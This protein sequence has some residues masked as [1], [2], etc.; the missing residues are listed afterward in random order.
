M[1]AM[2]E[3]IDSVL[4]RTFESLADIAAAQYTT[5]LDDDFQFEVTARF[6]KAFA[7]KLKK[8]GSQ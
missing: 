1:S 2:A 7:N 4:E 3:G 6:G 5:V 8:W